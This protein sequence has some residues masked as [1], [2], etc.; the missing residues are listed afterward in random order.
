MN[1]KVYTSKYTE[2]EVYNILTIKRLCDIILVPAKPMELFMGFCGIIFGV[3][4][5]L[6]FINFA[7][8]LA[9]MHEVYSNHGDG[10][11]WLLL[12][13]I[14]YLFMF[15]FT[16]AV[17]Y[18]ELI[19]KKKKI[20]LGC[21]READ[22]LCKDLMTDQIKSGIFYADAY[23]DTQS[24]ELVIV[25]KRDNFEIKRVYHFDRYLQQIIDE[26]QKIID[27]SKL[28]LIFGLNSVCKWRY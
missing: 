1:Y 27:L 24:N 14:L 22:R 10:F 23:V 4:S 13:S 5:V 19:G 7:S 21:Y 2:K 8:S 11:R 16:G 9:S 28:D 15:F 18:Q 17:S 20:I 26:E 3:M 6:S 25:I 12:S